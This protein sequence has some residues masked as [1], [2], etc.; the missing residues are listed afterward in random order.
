MKSRPSFEKS[1]GILGARVPLLILIMV[2]N[3]L[4]LKTSSPYG[5]PATAIS[6][7]QH[8]NDQISA[9]LPYPYLLIITSGA[10]QAKDPLI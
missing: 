2:S 9:F 5:F 6:M 3:I 1:L 10:I 8:P 7:T 4:F